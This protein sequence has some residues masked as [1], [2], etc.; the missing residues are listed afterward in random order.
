MGWCM[1]AAGGVG[2][3]SWLG[4]IPRPR[5]GF[6]DRDGLDGRDGLERAK[7][8]P[9]CARWGGILHGGPAPR[10]D[11]S[12]RAAVTSPVQGPP[13]CAYSLRESTAPRQPLH[14]RR[15]PGGRCPTGRA[16]QRGRGQ[17]LRAP[18][19]R[20]A[21]LHRTRRRRGTPHRSRWRRRGDLPAGRRRPRHPPRSRARRPRRPSA[22][23][24]MRTSGAG[25]LGA[26]DADRHDHSALIAAARS[27][28]G[29]RWCDLRRRPLVQVEG[30]HS[31]GPAADAGLAG[32]PGGHHGRDPF[33]NANLQGCDCGVSC[34]I[35][36]DEH[37]RVLAAPSVA[38][39]RDAVT[40]ADAPSATSVVATASV[41]TSP[42]LPLA[43]WGDEACCDPGVPGDVLSS[44]RIRADCDLLPTARVRRS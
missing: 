43:A 3:R 11:Q 6:P 39:L 33:R 21:D 24:A 35:Y 41:D 31:P 34:R 19:R 42:G 23:S 36:R 27:G 25:P 28:A 9:M 2:R 38:Q 1:G 4:R 30:L 40:A 14:V 20:A 13:T 16:G 7:R 8:A 37:G 22:G 15:V 17:P 26:E 10:A 5:Q 12:P 29:P 32:R 18:E 44:W